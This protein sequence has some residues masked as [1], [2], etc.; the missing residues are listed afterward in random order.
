MSPAAAQ[1]VEVVHSDSSCEEPAAVE[2]IRDDAARLAKPPL[3]FW[4]SAQHCLVRNAQGQKN[5]AKMS[6]VRVGSWLHGF[7]GSPS[8]LPK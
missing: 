8:P 7:I 5:L 6:E 3:Q 4:D 1:M 2:V